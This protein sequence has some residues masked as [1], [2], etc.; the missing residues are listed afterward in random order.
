MIENTLLI[1]NCDLIDGCSETI[2]KL[3]DILIIEGKIEKI[4]R[5]L[6][7][8]SNN[9]SMDNRG[10]TLLPG[11]IDTHVHLAFDGSD[12]PVNNLLFEHDHHTLIKMVM[13]CQKQLHNG[14][15]TVRDVGGPTE[16]IFALRESWRK[17]ILVGP[18]LIVSGEVITTKGG[19]CHFI[20]HEVA[21]NE[22]ALKAVT[23]GIKSGVDL[24]KIMATGGS[25]TPGSSVH[26]TQFLENEIAAI[27]E[28]AHHHSIKVAAH[29]NAVE[30]IR[31]AINANVDSIEHG[32]FADTQA[33][34]AMVQKGIYLVPTMSP[35]EIL[36]ESQHITEKR[37]S[38]VLYNW[39]SRKKVVKAAIDLGV[40][41]TS[42]TDAGT[43][44]VPHGCI[45]KEIQLFYKLGMNPMKAI[46]TATSWAAELLGICDEVGTI[47]E[48][49]A[50]DMI[51]VRGNPI[52]DLRR[53]ENPNLV[54][55]AGQIIMN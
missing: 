37:R 5:N 25:L 8:P 34:E 19:H 7:S 53:L 36:I 20:G 52:D 17:K 48:G 55:V 11:L 13:N 42:G 50:A 6:S 1:K 9:N 35:A 38:D 4:G 12:D 40:K 16:L 27:V 44:Y 29:A 46:W 43:T 22:S 18:R 26:V 41:M 33:L 28:K 39:E 10:M 30:G 21:C 51:G 47:E 15:T 54:I 14:V 31:N 49:K 2:Q 3:V 45:T 23:N 24:I 32:S